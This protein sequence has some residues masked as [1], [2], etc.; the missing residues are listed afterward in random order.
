MAVRRK[1]TTT[2]D[3]LEIVALSDNSWRV[4]DKG[5]DHEARGLLAYLE[6]V[7]GHVAVSIFSPPPKLDAVADCFSAAIAMV[8]QRANA[9]G[10]TAK[11]AATAPAP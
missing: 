1:G 8:S 9:G 6:R 4:T 5:F 7:D 10:T 3:D 11:A 2:D